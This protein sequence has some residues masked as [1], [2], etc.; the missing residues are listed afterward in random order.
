MRGILRKT[1]AFLR[2]LFGPERLPARAGATL[3]STQPPRRWRA[4][5]FGG[6]QLV[7]D[8][9]DH[10]ADRP[11]TALLSWVLSSERLPTPQ[12]ERDTP[13][14]PGRRRGL[15]DLLLSTEQLP[16]PSAQ[17]AG[18]RP[19]AKSLL[20]RLLS[21]EACPQLEPPARQRRAGFVRWLL[22]SE[23]L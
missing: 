10:A 2:W 4:W 11:R 13:A 3:A 19:A 16:R 1:V 7:S 18:P 17:A 12:G 22:S 15:R 14:S 21:P 5:L 6:D 20:P 23:R 9:S 8:A